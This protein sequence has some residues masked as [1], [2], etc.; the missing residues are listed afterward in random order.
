VTINIYVVAVN[1]TKYIKSKPILIPTNNLD[2]KIIND[3]EY[4]KKLENLI[5]KNNIIKK[6]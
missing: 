6:N 1:A 2:L 5:N 3:L 4:I